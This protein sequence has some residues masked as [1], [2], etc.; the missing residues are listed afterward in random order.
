MIKDKYA[1][2]CNRSSGV[3]ALLISRQKIN[4]QLVREV[5]DDS[6]IIWGILIVEM[7]DII[8]PNIL[9][10]PS[11][12]HNDSEGFYYYFGNNGVFKKVGNYTVGKY[13]TKKEER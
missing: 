1:L 11:V 3:V 6:R 4:G 7:S 12:N 8:K 13:V 2:K 9:A 5:R 10:S